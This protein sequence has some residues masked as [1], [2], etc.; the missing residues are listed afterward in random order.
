LMESL[1]H[2]KYQPTDGIPLDLLDK[3]N[4]TEVIDTHFN[5]NLRGYQ[6]FAV[7]FSIVQKRIIIGDE[8]GLGKT[9]EALGLLSHLKAMNAKHFLIVVPASVMI[10]WSRETE[11]HSKLTPYIIHPRYKKQFSVWKEAGG[12]GIITYD[13]LSIYTGLID[14][15]IDALVLDEAHYI[16]NSKAKRTQYSIKLINQSEHVLML[17][18]TP[19]ENR[20][21]EFLDLL[22]FLSPSLKGL[23]YKPGIKE[24]N[25]FKKIIAPY[26]LRRNR[27]EVLK[28]LPQIE[29]VEQWTQLNEEEITH[30]IEALKSSNFMLLR[31]IAWLSGNPSN[32]SKMLRLKDLHQE[33]IN[34]DRKIIVFSFFREV[35]DVI[36][37]EFSENAF[38]P[39]TGKMPS[40]ERIALIDQFKESPAGTMII[41]QVQAGG[42]GLNIQAASMVVICEP[43]LKPSTEEQAISR[44]YRMGQTNDVIVHRILTQESVDESLMEL[45]QTKQKIFNAYAKDSHLNQLSKDNE[46]SINIEK[47]VLKLE[48]NRYLSNSN[49]VI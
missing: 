47:E 28:E 42:V 3:I 22:S 11:T 49:S 46:S 27:T 44:V 2:N 14:F 25:Y 5:S 30:Y 8:M 37:K 40:E 36:Y 45:L 18:G 24:I 13:S 21:S 34:E 7:Q 1:S 32:T 20:L 23:Q 4:E 16:K 17:T 26:Y 43:Q 6:K 35:I 48:Q 29:Q 10:N 12:V 31:R 39:I 15:Q 38:T 19:L 33:A 9:I 41:S